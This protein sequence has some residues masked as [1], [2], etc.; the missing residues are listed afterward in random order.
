M[1]DTRD[2]ETNAYLDGELDDSRRAE[3]ERRLEAEPGLRERLDALRELD[4]SLRAL[5]GPSGDD[6]LLASRISREFS[7]RPDRRSPWPLV[8]AGALGAAAGYFLGVVSDPTSSRPSD[9]RPEPAASSWRADPGAAARIDRTAG[10]PRLRDRDAGKSRIVATND[11]VRSG[12]ELSTGDGARV[13]I[14]TADGSAIWLDERGRMTLSREGVR[15]HRGRAVVASAAGSRT[16]VTVGDERI[17]LAD[18][19]CAVESSLVATKAG[20]T[21]ESLSLAVI[22]GTVVIAGRTLS[23][24]ASIRLDGPSFVE[25]APRPDTAWYLAFTARVP[26]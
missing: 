1:N 19:A 22:R 16:V 26:D 5:A 24:G 25:N 13:A 3:F 8:L 4:A 20:G 14:E 15:L 6:R 2:L 10:E 7:P 18:G 9:R 17:E 21:L 11:V 12:G 23:A